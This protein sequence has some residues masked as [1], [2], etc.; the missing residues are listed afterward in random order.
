MKKLYMKKIIF[1][2]LLILVVT[3]CATR[4]PAE[5]AMDEAQKEL[6]YQLAVQSLNDRTFVVEADKLMFKR[7]RTAFVSSNSNFV[8]VNGNEATV[9]IAFTS[10]RFAG[11]NGIGGIT[12]D[13]TI[14][15]V[16]M[17]QRKNGSV[18]YSFNVQGVGISAQVNLQLSSSGNYAQVTVNPTFSSNRV[19]FSGYLVPLE[20]S[21]VYK[22]RSI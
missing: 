15:N 2:S 3:S 17:K 13:G 5:K 8:M 14:S 20:E 21:S 9:Q 4:T 16:E 7:G 18:D 11:P 10:S 6:S 1:L 19:N 22:G 12:L